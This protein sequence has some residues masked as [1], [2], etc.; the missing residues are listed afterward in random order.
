MDFAFLAYDAAEQIVAGEKVRAVFST[1][2]PAASH[3]AAAQLKRRYGIPW[4]A[5][6]RDPLAGNPFRKAGISSHMDRMAQAWI[7]RRADVLLATTD[8]TV[9]L[10]Q[11]QNP[12]H[13]GKMHV[14]WNGFDP[15]NLMQPAPIAKREYKVLVHAGV[16]YGV[17]DPSV[18][19]ASIHRLLRAGLLSATDLQI[20]LIGPLAEGRWREQ[21]VTRALV[22]QGCLQCDG[23]LVPKK[24]AEQAIS[25]ADALILLDSH[26]EGGAVQVP[27]KVFDYVRIGRPIVAVT[28]RN[29]PVD[30]LLS[31][32]GVPYSPLY[33][34]DSAEDVDRKILHFLT[35]PSEPVVA[36]SWF[37]KEFDAVFQARELASLIDAL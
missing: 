29:S 23:K 33:P 35:L 26:V 16:I 28:T 30:R 20:R 12:R 11:R 37:W 24:E 36:S 3:F 8:A 9:E 19:L 15:D 4:I 27:A 14:I 6:F 10:W 18:L 2:S 13:A 17:R 7:F 25:G 21:E 31:R 1:S 22:R 34:E 5:D 32:C